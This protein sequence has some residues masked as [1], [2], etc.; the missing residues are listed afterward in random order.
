MTTIHSQ[1][2]ASTVELI[3]TALDEAREL[4]KVEVALAQND[5][6]AQWRRART[7]AIA[8]VVAAGAGSAALAVVVCA[9]ALATQVPVTV[10]VIAALALFASSGAAA[11]IGLRAIPEK[12]LGRTRARL[13]TDVRELAQIGE[14]SDGS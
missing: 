6:D 14:H 13:E 11:W 9:V 4:V 12:L 2:S 8:F 7:A 5:L 1:E 3:K 10:S